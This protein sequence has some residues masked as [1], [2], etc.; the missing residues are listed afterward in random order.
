MPAFLLWTTLWTTETNEYKTLDFFLKI[1][2]NFMDN[3]KKA[4]TRQCNKTTKTP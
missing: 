2:T 3:E 1:L 4:Y